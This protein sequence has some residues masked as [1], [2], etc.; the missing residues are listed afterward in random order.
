MKNLLFEI[1]NSISQQ[2]QESQAFVIIS[3][4]IIILNQPDYEMNQKKSTITIVLQYVNFFSSV[5]KN[6]SL[7]L[8][9]LSFIH[10]ITITLFVI[11]I[12]IFFNIFDT[13]QIGHK[14]YKLAVFIMWVLLYTM[15]N[16]QL[17]MLQCDYNRFSICTTK[18]VAYYYFS[19]ITITSF[20]IF[21]A[22][23]IIGPFVVINNRF[24]KKDYLNC[25]DKI[26]FLIYNLYRLILSFLDSFSAQTIQ[27]KIS[28]PILTL[29]FLYMLNKRPYLVYQQN[30][31]FQSC[32]YFIFGIQISQLITYY[33]DQSLDSTY[34]LSVLLS[35]LIIQLQNN[36]SQFH[37]TQHNENVQRHI[38]QF[39]HLVQYSSD[40][41]YYLY[42]GVLFNHKNNRCAN[43]YC[44]C[45]QKY[46]FMKGQDINTNDITISKNSNIFYKQY[47]KSLLEQKLLTNKDE[48]INVY[49]A[50][51]LFH[52]LKM[53]GKAMITIQ[54]S[55]GLSTKFEVEFLKYQI[56][57]WIIKKDE[58][59]FYS[60]AEAL[61]R[62]DLINQI[63]VKMEDYLY[64]SIRFWKL[65][66]Q[67]Q[68]I[69]SEY[70]KIFRDM[71]V[72]VV[73]IHDLWIKFGIYDK[74]L[75]QKY[76]FLYCWCQ[77]FIQNKRVKQS[78]VDTVYNQKLQQI[79]EVDPMSESD[80]EV[81]EDQ[82][83]EEK[84]L[85]KQF[86]SNSVIIETNSDLDL[87][88]MNVCQNV[89]N[90]LGYNPTE[91]IGKSISSIIPDL[92][93]R[94]HQQ[95]VKNYLNFGRH[96][97]T[98]KRTIILCKHKQG[99]LIQMSK[100]LK[101]IIT[102]KNQLGFIA[103]IR[104]IHQIE[105]ILLNQ[106]WEIQGMT[107]KL[108]IQF[109]NIKCCIFFIS[110][111][112]IKHSLYG[113]YM[114]QSTQII[115][116]S[117]KSLISVNYV[118]RKQ[119][120][121]ATINRQASIF[122]NKKK[123]V[124]L[125]SQKIVDL[126]HLRVGFKIPETIQ[127]IQDQYQS[128]KNKSIHVNY[129]HITFRNEDGKIYFDKQKLLEQV[130][131]YQTKYHR[132][133]LTYFGSIFD[134][135]QSIVNQP[136]I[137][138]D[139]NVKF[140][141][142]RFFDQYITINVNQITETLQQIVSFV[143]SQ[144]HFEQTLSLQQNI[145]QDMSF[146]TS[147]PQLDTALISKRIVFEENQNKQQEMINLSINDNIF[148]KDEFNKPIKHQKHILIL[149]TFNRVFTLFVLIFVIIQY[150]QGFQNK[151]YPQI[152]NL[153]SLQIIDIS[154]LFIIIQQSYNFAIDYSLIFEN[155]LNN[156]VYNSSIFQYQSYDEYINYSVAELNESFNIIYY[157]YIEQDFTRMYY[158]ISQNYQNLSALDLLD[159]YQNNL[160]NLIIADKQ[161]Y[162]RNNSN[163]IS[164]RTNT[165]PQLK[166][167][168]DK[169][170][171]I[172]L[173]QCLQKFDDS[174]SSYIILLVTQIVLFMT[175]IC[176]N[177]FFIAI[178]IYKI[179]IG[180]RQIGLINKKSQEITLKYVIQKEEE[181]RLICQYLR[182]ISY[183]ISP[184]KQKKTFI[185][186]EEITNRTNKLE[187]SKEWKLKL[188]KLITINVLSIFLS[189]LV[190]FIYNLEVI[191]KSQSLKLYI[192]ENPFIGYTNTIWALCVFKEVYIYN[193][194]YKT[195]INLTS[196]L[197]ILD[198]FNLQIIDQNIY[199]SNI[200]SILDIFEGNL[201]QQIQLNQVEQN[202]CQTLISGALQRGIKEYNFLLNQ[203]I[204][205]F[206]SNDSRFEEVS[207][208][209]I[210]EY[211]N[212]F[213]FVIEGYLQA[214]YIWEQ[215]FMN[216]S[217]ELNTLELILM[218]FSMISLFFVYLISI[219]IYGFIQLENLF[220]EFRIFYKRFI[221]NDVV[222]N[223]KQIRVRYLRVGIIKK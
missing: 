33:Y 84:M 32:A 105:L 96:Y 56:Q 66:Q 166:S 25:D 79:F 77:L 24:S 115:P 199:Q 6:E 101:P 132:Q 47:I 18:S 12:L 70:L 34:S 220:N 65:F 36:L 78:I 188:I 139:V 74:N 148:F 138:L 35:I 193:K 196:Y 178:I 198:D 123:S 171:Q 16:L 93:L 219:E 76:I 203:L 186:E 217:Q 126:Q 73:Q 61:I 177:I 91:L 187:E 164:F 99:H 218:I 51:Y 200:Q 208:F 221:P 119:K 127:Y 197:E 9:I 11:S 45:R 205:G 162:S 174:Y 130:K 124:K 108:G 142:P 181:F 102:P 191:D 121:M 88:I 145:E 81:N 100:Y 103:M 155:K 143:K 207:L 153:G 82:L 118:H 157:L 22:F 94:N 28:K 95:S 173:N 54:K 13:I 72:L 39:E 55:Y 8:I 182:A 23:I 158:Q 19:G 21:L 3:F 167:S 52:K 117:S 62:E 159:L 125:N 179:K 104:Y 140:S 128:I 156:I 215:K 69:E 147:R 151:I 206:I 29:I 211:Q 204:Q 144:T 63:Q 194:F 60:F 49:Y 10:L 184:T 176:F 7:F 5:L 89:R 214:L 131:I 26:I 43:V 122:T 161:A 113:K 15:S 107:Y 137:K 209:K 192:T 185:S 223:D 50:N 201:C 14:T 152:H 37:P 134:N 213:D 183:S 135:Y 165:I 59:L 222:N 109:N 17:I 92:L 1:R 202:Y 80:D 129:N 53:N 210:Y 4:L 160:V 31:L 85:R 180:Y 141:N 169:T 146:D 27:I 133:I 48:Q 46:I 83:K 41:H 58:Q 97:S 42:I 175:L 190:P 112:L 110:P 172:L 57:Q 86:D 216:S 98:Y 71:Q 163:L 120:K 111:H 114:T 154:K 68:I 64:Y 149:K 168:I 75:Q 90:V 38:A 106:Y 44:F 170:L 195:E 116:Q 2:K 212:I 150:T 20:I 40:Q 136:S 189:S 67:K 87:K 30:H